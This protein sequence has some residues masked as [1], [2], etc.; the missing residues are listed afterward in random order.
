MNYPVKAVKERA[1]KLLVDSQVA[2]NRQKVLDAWQPVLSMRGEPKAGAEMFRQHCAVC[3]RLN[4][5]GQDVGP[6]LETVR[7]WTTEAMLTSI[8]D[9]SR[10]FEPKYVSYTATT[11]SGETIVGVI[12]AETGNSVTMKSVDGKE[13]T[14]LRTDLKSLVSSN[15]SLMPDGFE[16][17]MS[18][19]QLADLMQFLKAP[20][21]AK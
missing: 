13:R 10:Q 14:V 8:L 2:Q 21:Q 9:P 7:E 4:D 16:S 3:H 20:E 11:T 19:Q 1:A 15:R 12:T 17:A 6:N 5:A 18:K